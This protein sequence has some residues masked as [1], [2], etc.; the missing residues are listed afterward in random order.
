MSGPDRGWTLDSSA[1]EQLLDALHE[2]RQRAAVLYEQ[3]RER[4][5]GLLQWWG[6]HQGEDLADRTLDRVARK[7]QEGATIPDGSLGAY[8][9]GVA[10]MV[11]YE[12]TRSTNTQLEES[13]A[14]AL[15]AAPVSGDDDPALACLDRCL[16]ALAN[17]D[18]ALLLRYY[19][20]GKPKD[21]RREL[22][23]ETGMTATAL[24]LRIHRLRSRLERCVA[25]CLEGTG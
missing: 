21:L 3:L 25:S 18:R 20:A 24:R 11:F 19:D 13:V 17:D 23:G 4:T 6:S 22:A 5:I 8:V 7:I 2:D 10:R 14:E 1:F 9:R 16:A 12:S 15:V